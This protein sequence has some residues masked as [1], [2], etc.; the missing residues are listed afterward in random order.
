MVV[1]NPVVVKVLHALALLLYGTGAAVLTGSL[2]EGR[3]SVPRIGVMLAVAGLL[4]HAAGLAGFMMTYA[5]A[6]LVGLA[7]SLSTLSFLIAVFLLLS[8]AAPETRALG[9]VLLPLAAILVGTSLLLGIRPPAVDPQAYRGV[10]FSLHI[11]LAFTGFAGLALAFAS[12]LL[13]LLQFRQLKRKSFGR[14][15]RFFPP[16][17]TLDV[18]E[19]WAIA[20]GFPALT[21]GLLLGWAWTARFDAATSPSKIAWALVSWVV[22]A[23]VV[24]VRLRGGGE[25]RGA[26]A[27]VA[28][29]VVVALLYLVLRL[30][31][32]PVEA[33]L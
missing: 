11:L 29:F 21:A 33:F 9:L 13:Y 14:M 16:L 17:E 27:A 32:G 5:E 24:A 4:V 2:A 22:F 12:G 26:L 18:V 8:A 3:R 30:S 7:P 23:V 28:G 25:R 31:L 6:P 15:F 19:R 10:W 1:A 20:A